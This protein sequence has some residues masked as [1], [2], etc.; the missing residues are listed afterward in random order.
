MNYVLVDPETN[1]KNVVNL[2]NTNPT[3]LTSTI[4]NGVKGEVLMLGLKTF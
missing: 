3:S 2:N 1:L 4:R